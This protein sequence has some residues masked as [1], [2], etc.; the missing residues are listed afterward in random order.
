MINL[1]HF[2]TIKQLNFTLDLAEEL[3]KMRRVDGFF[4]LVI[5]IVVSL[6]AV[7]YFMSTS[8]SYIDNNPQQLAQLKR[9]KELVLVQ[10]QLVEIKNKNIERHIASINSHSGQE[11]P[12]N[13]QDLF[14][15]IKK[16]CLMDISS[17]YCLNQIEAMVTQFPDTIWAGESMLILIESYQANQETR[18]SVELIKILKD[19]FSEH[20]IIQSKIDFFEKRI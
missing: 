4:I 12:E 5:L 3:Y 11:M 16:T 2:E 17:S 18:K 20:K 8:K 19:R 6:G 7:F 1:V 9:Q 14:S 13:A 10:R 15:K